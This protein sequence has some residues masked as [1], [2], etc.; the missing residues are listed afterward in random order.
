MDILSKKVLE[1]G[2]SC[3]FLSASAENPSIY[4][5]F[6]GEIVKRD[7]ND[8]RICYYVQMTEVL[9]SLTF[10]KEYLHQTSWRT[11]NIIGNKYRSFK[12]FRIMD[13][14]NVAFCKRYKTDLQVVPMALLYT[15]V[16]DMNSE[17]NKINI[18]LGNKLES[19]YK[20]LKSVASR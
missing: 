20:R 11:I 4:V 12:E 15:S 13:L 6:K 3:Y 18:H 9:E 2:S 5:R 19:D 17:L 10:A 1:I 8:D 7:S 16:K 14:L